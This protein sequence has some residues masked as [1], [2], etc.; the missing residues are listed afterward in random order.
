V[1]GSS[2]KSKAVIADLKKKRFFQKG[3]NEVKR[4][5]PSTSCHKKQPVPGVIDDREQGVPLPKIIDKSG[6]HVTWR[7]L[8]R[9]YLDILD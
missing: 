4:K 2:F 3:H 1:R 7:L 8:L 9:E 5:G 6:Q